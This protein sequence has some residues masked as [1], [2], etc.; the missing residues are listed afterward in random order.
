[1]SKIYSTAIK[2]SQN[3]QEQIPFL[4][5][6]YTR[7][8][9]VFSIWKQRRAKYVSNHPKSK[10]GIGEKKVDGILILIQIN[11]SDRQDFLI[12][13]GTQ[14]RYW[15]MKDSWKVLRLEMMAGILSSCGRIV[16]LK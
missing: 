14:S 2:V 16:H 1:L 4:A 9:F 10:A 11:F 5:K 12:G 6:V 7:T 3:S 8:R 15:F 13:E